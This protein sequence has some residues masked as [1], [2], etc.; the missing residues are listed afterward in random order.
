MISL[1]QNPNPT[2]AQTANEGATNPNTA[3]MLNLHD[4]ISSLLPFDSA[5]NNNTVEEAV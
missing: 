4:V 2:T 1:H 5:Q 3:A